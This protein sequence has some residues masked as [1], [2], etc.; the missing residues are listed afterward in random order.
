MSKVYFA[1]TP[2]PEYGI[3]A[4]YTRYVSAKEKHYVVAETLEEYGLA[5][6]QE[7]IEASSWCELACV[8]DEYEGEKFTIEVIEDDE[9]YQ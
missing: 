1:I 5:D 8:G 2:K 7:A 4:G 9:D 6:T 3:A